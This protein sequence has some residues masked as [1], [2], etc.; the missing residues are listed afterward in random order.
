LAPTPGRTRWTF[1]TGGAVTATPGVADGAVYVGSGDG[2]VYALSERS[3]A[4]RWATPVGAPV[5]AGG[6][7]IPGHY[8]VGDRAGNVTTLARP[9]GAIARVMGLGSA[10]VGLA[11][12]EDWI[13]ATTAA[14]QVWGIKS[15]IVWEADV[16]PFAAA[17]TVVDGVVY[18]TATDG[19]LDADTIPGT[20]IP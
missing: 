11:G 3:G 12:A 18:T 6:V 19:T 16:A 5:S 9:S 4:L 15:S 7:L 13:A 2:V 1:A 10:V 17:P 14:G 8:V 20:P